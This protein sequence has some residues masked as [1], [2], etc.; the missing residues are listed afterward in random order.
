V[1]ARERPPAPP[2]PDE[3]FAEV[4][5]RADVREILQKLAKR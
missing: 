2:A 5:K 1:A 4:I 3:F